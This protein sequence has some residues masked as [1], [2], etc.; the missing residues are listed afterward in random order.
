MALLH[1]FGNTSAPLEPSSPLAK[2]YADTK[3]TVDMPPLLL[4][5]LMNN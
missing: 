5:L 1:V 2:F 3:G 4:H